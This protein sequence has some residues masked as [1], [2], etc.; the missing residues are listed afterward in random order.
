MKSIRYILPRNRFQEDIVYD[1]GS[2]GTRCYSKANPHYFKDADG[3]LYPIDV[4][5]QEEGTTGKGNSKLR[6]KNV[7]SVGVRADGNLDK[8]VGIRPDFSQATGEHQLEFSLVRVEVD[9]VDQKVKTKTKA[10]KSS[11]KNP[12]AW[13]MGRYQVITSRQYCRQAVLLDRPA[14]SFRIEFLIHVTGL[15]ITPVNITE[16]FTKWHVRD[17]TGEVNW[18]I[19]DPLILDE[20]FEVIGS[21]KYVI[22]TLMDNSDGTFTYIKESVPGADYSALP[23]QFWVDASTVYSDVSDGRVWSESLYWNTVRVNTTAG[24]VA[25]SENFN[26]LAIRAQYYSSLGYS[27]YNISRAFLHFDTSGI[28][29]EIIAAS[30]FVYGAGSVPNADVYLQEGIQALPLVGTSFV[31]YTGGYLGLLSS[32]N[33]DA[34]NQF[35]L[36]TPGIAKINQAG[37]TKYC[38]RHENDY[39]NVAPT[40]NITS[41][42]MY[43][44]DNAGT[45]RDPYLYIEIKRTPRIFIY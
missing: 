30:L 38:L 14:E 4:T 16:E 29:G 6:S 20:N 39:L 37:T 10:P 25:V 13:D 19:S 35:V 5:H 2:R 7:A 17:V 3:G 44:T 12:A 31:S 18:M 9:G 8:A 40:S 1:D 23:E 28:H 42:G 43:F 33:I 41:A 32:W 15:I 45:T 36:S 24:T 21:T 22:H 26:F 27:Y 34:A 11:I